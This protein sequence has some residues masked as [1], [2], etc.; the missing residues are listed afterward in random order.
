MHEAPAVPAI[1]PFSSSDGTE[2]WFE[3]FMDYMGNRDDYHG[4]IFHRY[5]Q[6]GDAS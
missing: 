4:H 3:V 6:V 2:C 1:C 5:K